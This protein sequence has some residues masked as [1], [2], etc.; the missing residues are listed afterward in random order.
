MFIGKRLISTTKLII[1]GKLI[2]GLIGVCVYQ[3]W[4]D[5]Y[6]QMT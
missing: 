4:T 2:Q 1:K 5:L 3:Q 6:N